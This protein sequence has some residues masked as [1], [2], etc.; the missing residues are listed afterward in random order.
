MLPYFPRWS[1]LDHLKNSN[2]SCPTFLRITE[3]DSHQNCGKLYGKSG[4]EDVSYKND[5]VVYWAY[6]V[7]QL[8]CFN[9][10]NT[11]YIW[12]EAYEFAW[13]ALHQC[14][15]LTFLILKPKLGQNFDFSTQKLWLCEPKA[16]QKNLA[17]WIYAWA[18]LVTHWLEE[19]PVWVYAFW[20]CKP[21]IK[22]SVISFGSK[23]STISSFLSMS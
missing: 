10:K 19:V 7:P 14:L 15:V 2:K 9:V 17:K 20:V 5:I 4:N 21:V 22:G 13:W 6:H 11:R 1:T 8:R 3:V 12:L 16:E 23:V 18:D